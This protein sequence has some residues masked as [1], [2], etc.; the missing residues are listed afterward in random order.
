MKRFMMLVL[1]GIVC[2]LASNG[3]VLAANV[4]YVVV[5]DN[6]NYTVEEAEGK[7]ELFRDDHGNPVTDLNLARRIAQIAFVKESILAKKLS[8][9]QSAIASIDTLV[10]TQEGIG[11]LGAGRDLLARTFADCIV[12]GGIAGCLVPT[13]PIQILVDTVKDPKVYLGSAARA[14]AKDA[15][16]RY[17]RILTEAER[18]LQAHKPLDDKTAG[19]IYA[20]Y[21]QAVREHYPSTALLIALSGLNERLYDD[22]LKMGK[23]ASDEFLRRS[24]G[25]VGLI[26]TT[27]EVRRA[28]QYGQK[29]IESTPHVRQFNQDLQD[30]ARVVDQLAA[31]IAQRATRAVHLATA[32]LQTPQP[33]PLPVQST[34][35]APAPLDAAQF[36]ADVTIPD[37]TTLQPGQSFTKTWRLR[38]TGGTTWGS[39]YRLGF[40]SGAALSAPN[41]VPVP[42]MAPGS[43]ADV[44]VNMVAP[45]AAGPYQSS[46][47]LTNAQGGRFGQTIWVKVAVSTPAAVPSLTPTPVPPPSPSPVI[48]GLSPNPVSGTNTRQTLTLLGSGF[49]PGLTV[50]LR[51]GGQSYPIPP[52]RT[53]VVSPTQVQILVDVTTQSAAWTAQVTNPGGRTSNAFTFNVAAPVQPAS[54]STS[55]SCPPFPATPG[56]P[57]EPTYRG[58]CTWYAADR[59]LR[60]G[61]PLPSVRNAMDW[62]DDAKGLFKTG[63]SPMPGSLMILG[64]TPNNSA[65]HVAYV[66]S[67]NSQTQS[68]TVSEMNWGSI[69]DIQNIKTVNF[70]KVTTRTLASS[71]VPGRQFIYPVKS[72]GSQSVSAAPVIS[73][74][75]PNPVTGANARQ[76][77]TLFGSGF[78]PGLTVT[79]R[80]GGQSYPIPPDRT[81]VMSATQVQILADVT[82]QAAT[83]TAQVTNPGGAS[84]NPFSFTVS[85]PPAAPPPP[86]PTPAH[87]DAAQFV[88]DVTIPDGTTLSPGQTFTK[89]WRLRNTG[90]TIWSSGYR[91]ALVSGASLGAPSTVAVPPTAPG[92]TADVSVPM[93]APSGAGP[94]QGTWQLMNAQGTRFGQTIWV[95]VAVSTPAAAPPPPTA[96]NQAPTLLKTFSTG[97]S[98]MV[99][100]GYALTFTATDP[101]ANL[102]NIDV[103]WNDGSAVEHK[104]VSGNQASVTFTRTFPTARTVNWSATAYD[105]KGASSPMLGGSFTVTAVPVP[106]SPPPASPRITGLSPNPVTGANVRQALT[107]LGSGFVPGL[108]VTLRTG[109]QSYPIPPERTTVVS[110]TQVQVLVDVT[111]TSAAWTAQVTNPGG[112]GS[113]LF[114]FNVKGK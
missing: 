25:S 51:T 97:A 82:T 18:F 109:G 38:N 48:S 47:Q 59:W 56:N 107:L 35:Q 98:V 15:Q 94:Y 19:A 72:M 85:A 86:A 46:W 32:A 5:V 106:Q 105:T 66:E 41:S 77:L 31:Q 69:V 43:T 103:N 42:V 52:D 20:D 17:Q 60:N 8:G 113:N 90:T 33:Q 37:G 58:Y 3:A 74:L 112:A 63:D 14:M 10:R 114:Y 80:T 23:V 87:M 22:L 78:M 108:T 110:P 76:T 49:A 11:Y 13:T 45:S 92:N 34:P 102:A 6:R 101:D 100:Q 50:T 70:C 88:A 79:L 24:V 95:K 62:V 29:W 28:L 36:V 68:F 65:G 2:L 55:A 81:T 91:L 44:S 54:A 73:S 40:V 27:D 16:G 96:A 67:V 64:P 104:T 4:K 30:Q 9:L 83:W 111:T 89:T 71:P 26:A 7:G 57:F 93:T 21:V 99:G 12:G 75:S 61:L 84:S 39:G 1:V 53:T